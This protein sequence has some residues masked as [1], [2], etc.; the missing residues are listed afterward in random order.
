[1][2][3]LVCWSFSNL[4]TCGDVVDIVPKDCSTLV[5]LLNVHL[6]LLRLHHKV[7]RCLTHHCVSSLRTHQRQISV[8]CIVKHILRQLTLTARPSALTFNGWEYCHLFKH[9]ITMLCNRISATTALSLWVCHRLEFK[10]DRDCPWQLGWLVY[11]FLPDSQKD[12][13]LHYLLRL[14]FKCRELKFSIG[15]VTQALH[16]PWLTNNKKD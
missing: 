15:A 12:C 3:P 10:S 5:S 11:H 13:C 16:S 1:V 14:T 7:S 2:Q 6:S 9:Q 4:G 8:I